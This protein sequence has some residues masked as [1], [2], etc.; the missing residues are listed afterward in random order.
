MNPE[1]MSGEA[2]HGFAGAHGSVFEAAD[3]TNEEQYWTLG[4]WITLQEALTALRV[5][6]PTD[7]G[8]HDADEWDEY[9]LIEI[10]E[11]KIGWCG[12]G[13]V[14]AKMEWR[15]TYD[16][17]SDEYKWARTETPNSDSTTQKP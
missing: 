10:R 15:A 4:I 3:A 13:K 12:S 7:V 5:D 14:V 11:R 17:A 16:E 8:C 9:R 6:D 1:Q 2:G